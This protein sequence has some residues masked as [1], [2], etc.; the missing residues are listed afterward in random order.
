MQKQHSG[1]VMRYAGVA[2]A[3][4]GSSVVFCHD[5]FSAEKETKKTP[6]P[7]VTGGCSKVLIPR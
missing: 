3:K 2:L 7:L 1:A 4:G 5:K 6:W